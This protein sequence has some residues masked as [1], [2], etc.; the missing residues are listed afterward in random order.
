MRVPT[1]TAAVHNKQPHCLPVVL[2]RALGKQAQPALDVVLRIVAM[3]PSVS[4]ARGTVLVEFTRSEMLVREGERTQQRVTMR[5]S[6]V[7]GQMRGHL[8]G[9]MVNRVGMR[10]R[11]PADRLRSCNSGALAREAETRSNARRGSITISQARD[12]QSDCRGREGER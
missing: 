9:V 7:N 1:P 2:S 4:A 11:P 5:A 10:C 8:A 12:S 6:A 3:L